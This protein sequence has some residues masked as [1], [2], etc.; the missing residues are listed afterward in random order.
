MRLMR[1]LL[2]GALATQGCSSALLPRHT[3]ISVASPPETFVAFGGDA[4]QVRIYRRNALVRLIQLPIDKGTSG[5]ASVDDRGRLFIG[6]G[7]AGHPMLIYSP[8]YKDANTLLRL[9]PK[10]GATSMAYLRRRIFIAGLEETPS[11]F[12]GTVVSSSPRTRQAQSLILLPLG[13][14]PR[15]LSL[16]SHGDLLVSACCLRNGRGAIFDY[17]PPYTKS[18][19]RIFTSPHGFAEGF[20]YTSTETLFVCAAT[21]TRKR[22]ISYER[23]PFDAKPNLL[24]EGPDALAT[25][26]SIGRIFI[27]SGKR[28]IRY[29]PPYLRVSLSRT[30]HFDGSS[31]LQS[32]AADKKGT[33]LAFLIKNIS[34]HE[35]SP[36]EFGISAFDGTSGTNIWNTGLLADPGSSYGDPPGSFNLFPGDNGSNC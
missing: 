18:P 22:S 13:L 12:Q 1:C 15:R 17:K 3:P 30:I 33:I 27:A 32:I 6:P 7:A 31:S 35:P 34:L 29:D 4:N 9:P 5:F 10:F 11:G 36:Q 20:V 16:D 24:F 8:P 19:R 14:V 2:L 23:Y 25:V 21:G 26:D 28:L